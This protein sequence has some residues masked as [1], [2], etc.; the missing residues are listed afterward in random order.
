MT[1]LV[2]SDDPNSKF[3]DFNGRV[4][5]FTIPAETD[6]NILLKNMREE[7][8]FPALNS[9]GPKVNIEYGEASYK[10][11]GEIDESK[12]VNVTQQSK[13]IP[14]IGSAISPALQNDLPTADPIMNDF[15][16]FAVKTAYSANQTKELI[17]P[18]KNANT[19]KNIRV[20]PYGWKSI[21]TPDELESV[22]PKRTSPILADFH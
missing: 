14:A 9:L 11:N 10:E 4:L 17:D 6:V 1:L 21:L 7:G 22:R 16:K 15:R 20:T 2:N 13:L 12:L 19:A 3:K 5:K 8:M 18:F